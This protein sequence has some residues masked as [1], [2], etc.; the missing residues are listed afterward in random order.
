ML[1]IDNLSL[2]GGST[3]E[4]RPTVA[5]TASCAT[6]EQD[7]ARNQTNCAAEAG[8]TGLRSRSSTQGRGPQGRA[9]RGC[10]ANK[11]GALVRWWARTSCRGHIGPS[12][13]RGAAWLWF[14]ALYG[15][16]KT[17]NRAKYI[18]LYTRP[19][20]KVSVPRVLYWGFLLYTF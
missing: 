2:T 12:R 4:Q 14:T 3:S 1:Q 6:N 20:Y 18:K 17:L 19:I 16:K 10:S 5:A 7:S 8:L 11:A 15:R 9:G 13:A